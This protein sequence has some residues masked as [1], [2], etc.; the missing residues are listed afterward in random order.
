MKHIFTLL[1]SIITVFTSHIYSYST[2]NNKSV[3]N[4]AKAKS[5]IKEHIINQFKT[6]GNYTEYNFGELT[7]IKPTEI[8]ELDKLM[9][10]KNQL[11]SMKK[12]YGNKLDSMIT[13]NDSNIVRKKRDIR[14]GKIYHYYKINHLF[15]ISYK[16]KS[17]LYEFDFFLYPNCKIKDV[18]LKMKTDIN[19]TEKNN[20]MYFISNQPLI[21]TD[22][23]S[24][25]QHI[26]DK[27]HK[28][29]SNALINAGDN[30]ETILHQVLKIVRFIRKHNKFDADVFCASQLKEWVITN[31]P[32]KQNYR[33]GLFTRLKEVT[34]DSTSKNTI[35]YHKLSYQKDSSQK[36]N[37]AISFEFDANY[38]V[39]EIIEYKKDYAK[40]F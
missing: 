9:T 14:E 30:K 35:M 23:L 4:L 5:A 39:I 34:Q 24:Y 6:K 25:Q 27:M 18:S 29:L 12:N 8:K 22:N 11:P 2:L 17:T 26:N 31:E 13:L 7:T 36:T 1:F 21:E 20:L 40:F 3:E 37:C 28:Q 32:Y 33:S 16:G 19:P 38:L 10:L 15:T